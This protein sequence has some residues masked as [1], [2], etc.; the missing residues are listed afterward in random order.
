M[1]LN[2]IFHYLIIRLNIN[3][4]TNKLIYTF[5]HI[6]F[7]LYNFKRNSLL[8]KIISIYMLLLNYWKNIPICRIENTSIKLSN[9]DLR[10]TYL[11]EKMHVFF[12]NKYFINF[13]MCHWTYLV[14]WKKK[15]VWYV[16]IKN[17]LASITNNKFPSMKR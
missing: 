17:I 2:Y 8:R 5:L 10:V 13:W 15:Y 6:T 14:K 12:I 3:V 16:I 7:L 9:F 11:L 1:D 4:W